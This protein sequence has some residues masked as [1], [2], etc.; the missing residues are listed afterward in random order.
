M[1]EKVDKNEMSK[2][3]K[4]AYGNMSSYTN[5][6]AFLANDMETQKWRSIKKILL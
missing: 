6:S 2:Q 5:A 1:E 4:S 3:Q